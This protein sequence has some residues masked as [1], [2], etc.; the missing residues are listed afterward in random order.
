[1]KIKGD[2]HSDPGLTL[3]TRY[4]SGDHAYAKTSHYRGPRDERNSDVGYVV[5]TSDFK[6]VGV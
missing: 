4:V 5:Q 2:A 6:N 1:M 3:M